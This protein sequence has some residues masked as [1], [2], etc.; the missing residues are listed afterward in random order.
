MKRKI[1]LEGIISLLILLFLYTG[2][3]QLLAYKYFHGNIYNQP[4]FQWS[5]PILVYAVPGAQLLIVAALLFERTRLKALWASLILLSIFTVYIAMILLNM[6]ARVP[7]SCGGVIS[8]FTWP[9]HLMFNL[10]FIILNII[11]ILMMKKRIP[12]TTANAQMVV[13]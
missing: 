3:T 2:L 1:A 13:N 5:K 7:C 12:E 8:S 6:L 4:I 11:A 10:F 9:Q